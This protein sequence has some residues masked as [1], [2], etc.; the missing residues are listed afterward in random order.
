MKCILKYKG[1]LRHGRANS[2]C[3]SNNVFPK[4]LCNSAGA[5]VNSNGA[6][7]H[8]YKPHGVMMAVKD[9]F[10]DKLS[11]DQELRCIFFLSN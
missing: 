5:F 11:V 4:N 10:G 1:A 7:A 6:L 9:K 3:M 2:S 8:S